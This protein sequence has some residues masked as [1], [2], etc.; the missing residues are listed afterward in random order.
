[1]TLFMRF[2]Q[3]ASWGSILSSV[4]LC[5]YVERC[6]PWL[7]STCWYQFIT[8][9]Y[10][11]L[12]VSPNEIGTVKSSKNI[13]SFG[14]GYQQYV[15]SVAELGVHHFTLLSSAPEFANSFDLSYLNS[16]SILAKNY[17]VCN[18]TDIMMY[19]Y[20]RAKSLT[21]ITKSMNVI[22]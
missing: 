11:H 14:M 19:I 10:R 15:F 22:N 2:P 9:E 18:S 12:C 6:Y 21:I 13:R 7:C 8:V 16:T 1:M 3:R 17:L 5:L 20:S 4:C